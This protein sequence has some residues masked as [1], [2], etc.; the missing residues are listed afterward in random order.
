MGVFHVAIVTIE[1]GLSFALPGMIFSMF[2]SIYQIGSSIS[3]GGEE[4]WSHFRLLKRTCWGLNTILK[5]KKGCL[6]QYINCGESLITVVW[7]HQWNRVHNLQ[8]LV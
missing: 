6:V 1:N 8:F 3:L 7:K 2:S 5:Y 4:A